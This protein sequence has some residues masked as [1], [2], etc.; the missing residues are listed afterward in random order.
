MARNIVKLRIGY[1]LNAISS[2]TVLLEDS[3]SF[4]VKCRVTIFRSYEVR[5]E[6]QLDYKCLEQSR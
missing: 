4:L 5:L 6:M 2:F 1:L 3:I